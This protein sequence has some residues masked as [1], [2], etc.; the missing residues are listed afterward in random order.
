MVQFGRPRHAVTN[1]PTKSRF[2]FESSVE[3]LPVSAHGNLYLWTFTFAEVIDVAEGRRRWS[4]FLNKL[5]HR[6]RYLKLCGLRVYEL[7]PG[8]HGLHVHVLTGHFLNV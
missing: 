2:A 4:R 6:R 1:L 3:W 7:H 8:G 5:R